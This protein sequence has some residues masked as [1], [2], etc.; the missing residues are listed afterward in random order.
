MSNKITILVGC[1]GRREKKKDTL[2][3]DTR[4]CLRRWTTSTASTSPPPR[5]EMISFASG[6]VNGSGSLLPPAPSMGVGSRHERGGK[7]VLRLP[8]LP[9]HLRRFRPGF[10]SHPDLREKEVRQA[11]PDDS[12]PLS[13][14]F[15]LLLSPLLCML[16]QQHT[17]RTTTTH[18]LTNRS[19]FFPPL[20]PSLR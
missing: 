10:V 6:S 13:H 1:A 11:A 17:A 18:N 7:A 12:V 15:D 19:H 8:P 5:R 2:H 16:Q 3:V 4:E 20:P 14:H 9:R